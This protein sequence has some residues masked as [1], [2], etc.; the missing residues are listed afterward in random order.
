MEW[1]GKWCDKSNEWS[2]VTSDIKQKLLFADRADGGFWMTFDDFYQ[3]YE[4]LEICDLTPAAFSDELNTVHRKNLVWNLIGHHG[5]WKC[6]STAGGSGNGY[7]DNLYWTNPQF[8]I[9][10]NDCDDNDGE[11]LATIIISLM[12]KNTREKRMENNGE[13]A[14]NYIQFRLYRVVQGKHGERAR[15][16]GEKL[17]GS[18]LE[19]V[20]T[21]GSY[22]NM[23]DLTKRF[24]VPPG[25]YVIIPSTYEPHVEGEFLLRLFTEKQVED[26]NVKELDKHNELMLRTMLNQQPQK[27][28]E[29]NLTL[30]DWRKTSRFYPLPT[31]KNLK[32][33][34]QYNGLVNRLLHG[35]LD[36]SVSIKVTAKRPPKQLPA[37]RKRG[38]PMFFDHI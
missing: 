21:S 34:Q 5:A 25:D 23:R 27:L 15:K 17:Y 2:K 4:Q 37:C 26:K 19:L 33:M 11:N 12:Q 31:P 10:L 38:F 36:N 8:L 29:K 7:D 1:N 28:V 14:E 30:R 35:D 22:I 9:T 3:N 24:R 32:Q 18:Q 13:P 16:T 6:G 20:S